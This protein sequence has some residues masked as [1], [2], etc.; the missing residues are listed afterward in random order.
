ML[1][2]IQNPTKGEKTNLSNLL[3]RYKK[4]SLA[5]SSFLLKEMYMS[6]YKILQR[7]MFSLN[8]VIFRPIKE[9]EQTSSV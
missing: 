1:D 5:K 9:S 6:S 4:K 8:L 2:A 7:R 3:G